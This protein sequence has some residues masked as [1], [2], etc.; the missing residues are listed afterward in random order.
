MA[1]KGNDP[2]TRLEGTATSKSGCCLGE[3]GIVGELWALSAG[4]KNPTG[5]RKVIP[6]LVCFCNFIKKRS[7]EPSVCVFFNFFF[8]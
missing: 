7:V 5:S 2:A 8:N 4:G 1:F 3:I 6:F